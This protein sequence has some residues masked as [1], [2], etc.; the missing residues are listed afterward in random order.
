MDV[1]NASLGSVA[2][3]AMSDDALVQAV[4][5]AAEAG[6]IVVTAAG[7]DG[8]DPMLVSSPSTSPLA[9]SVANTLNSRVFGT[10]LTLSD[11]Q[12][13][14][15]LPSTNVPSTADP[16]S[17][18][19]A[20]VAALDPTG[21]ACTTLPANSL[22]SRVALIFRGTCNFSTKI[23]NAEAAGASGAIIYSQ[24]GNP[25]GGWDPQD[26]L[27]PAVLVDNAAGLKVK[28]AVAAD[29]GLTATLEFRL[30]AIASDPNG[31]EE[32]SSRG[33]GPEGQIKPDLS[34]TGT[35]I[36]TAWISPA[37]GNPSYTI[38][39]G[40]SLSSPIVAGAAALLKQSKPGLTPAQ[41]RS[42]LVNSASPLF[43][44]GDPANP[45]LL[46]EQGA[47]L[48]TAAAALATNLTAVPLSVP[49]G[50][51]GADVDRT[52][53]V[54]LTNTGAQP[55]T[56]S[57]TVAPIGG[58]PAP[59]LTATSITLEPGAAQEVQVAIEASGLSAGAYQGY[60]LAQ[61]SGST[62]PVRIPYWYGVY[63][64]T[65]S[66]LPVVFARETGQVR[67]QQTILFRILGSAGVPAIP[68]KPPQFTVVSGGGSIVDW[69]SVDDYYPNTWGL[70]VR[71][72]AARATDNVFDI[73]VGDVTSRVTIRTQ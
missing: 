20:D 36:L 23:K 39:D 58:G 13:F 59:R 38:V 57:L 6:V 72:G 70:L 5:R 3:D 46:H 41:Y 66:F 55:E 69:G 53:K 51:G 37:T 15:T 21:L 28:N 40:T 4:N 71:L 50:F 9:L 49:F 73:Q 56:Y 42:L 34:A 8:P 19:V 48:L 24:A 25:I 17:G 27:L 68:E 52:A 63:G 30:R 44:K 33:P 1:I 43:W 2:I 7:N 31:M 22:R 29:S 62:A 11:G 10:A 45:I 32:G 16:V 12:S 26:A 35:E 64:T 65:A 61:G 60:V 14:G 18:V 54:T 47:G 67:S